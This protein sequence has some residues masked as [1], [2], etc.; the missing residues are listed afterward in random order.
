MKVEKWNP[1]KHMPLLASWLKG[2]GQAED[3]GDARY[4]PS[5]GFVVDEC[6][7]GFLYATNAPLVG[8]L[9]GIVT[10]PAAPARRRY[11]ALEALCAMLLGLSREMGIELLCASTSINGLV[12]ICQDFGFKVYGSGYKYIAR[13]E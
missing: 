3:A 10:D 4:Y 6:A 8:Y 5:T 7:M 9:D 13:K 12:G 1:E 11:H 2:R